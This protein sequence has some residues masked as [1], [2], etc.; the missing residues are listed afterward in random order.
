[1]Y[2][3]FHTTKL[4]KIG[5]ILQNGLQPIYGANSAL[6]ADG[7]T[8]KVSYSAGLQ[9]TVT[10]FSVFQ[11]FYNNVIEGRID[12]DSF[13]RNLSTEEYAI[14]KKSI[15]E[16]QKSGSF[17]NWISDN[18]YLCFDG[19]CISNKN[20]EKPEDAYTSE[21]IP[22]EKLKVCIIKSKKDDSMCSFS[23]KDIYCF[24]YAK[25]PELKKGLGTWR[26]EE[27]I[28]KFRNDDYYMDYLSLEQF[29]ELFPESTK[30]VSK[31]IKP[32]DALRAA[33]ASGRTTD[34]VD[35]AKKGDNERTN[36]GEIIHEQ[37]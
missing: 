34:E 24:L 6:T 30:G 32:I 21:F 4:E 14:H 19:D 25:N 35:M 9:A 17:V 15:A 33:T 2:S 8:G 7:R 26:F 31:T 22:P 11:R 3:C 27:D 16:I 20:E 10:T 5:N 13:K 23:M 12:E 18:V 37:Q 29:C 36:V 28:N 1:M